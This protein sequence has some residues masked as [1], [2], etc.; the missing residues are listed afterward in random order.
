WQLQLVS[1]KQAKHHNR[2]ELS[3]LTVATRVITNSAL[4]RKIGNPLAYLQRLREQANAACR[5]AT[6]AS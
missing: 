6:A 5:P 1:R 2:A 4:M 3:V